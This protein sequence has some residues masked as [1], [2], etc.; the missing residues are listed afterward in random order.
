[1]NGDANNIVDS[2]SAR[3]NVTGEQIAIARFVYVFCALY[4]VQSSVAFTLLFGDQ[5]TVTRQ[6][7]DY[8]FISHSI[9]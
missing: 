7:I 9:Y 8:I 3:L 4:L 6:F 2:N 1:M 5:Y